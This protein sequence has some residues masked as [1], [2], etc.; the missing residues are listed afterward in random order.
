[1]AIRFLTYAGP[2]FKQL[3]HARTN[4]RVH[5]QWGVGGGQ[6]NSAPNKYRILSRVENHSNV[7]TLMSLQC[8]VV[9]LEVRN[10]DSECHGML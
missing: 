8:I 10:G 2:P 6:Y 5:P 9:Q 7:H 4:T 3:H 1:M